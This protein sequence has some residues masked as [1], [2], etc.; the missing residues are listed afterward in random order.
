MFFFPEA[1]LNHLCMP[2]FVKLKLNAPPLRLFFMLLVYT[3]LAPLLHATCVHLPCASSSCCL[4]TPPLHLFFMLLVCTSLAPFLHATCVHLPC[5][6][7]SCC[8]CTPPL[9]L[10][11]MLL[12]YREGA[13]AS[14]D[15]FTKAAFP[16]MSSKK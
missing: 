16:K 1:G 3:S 6:S 14:F 9:H 7:S 2:S 5:T 10:F 11:F 4:C 15:S 8:L 12:V 13:Q